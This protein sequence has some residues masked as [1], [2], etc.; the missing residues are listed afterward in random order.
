[1]A[2][3][4]R[5]VSSEA[6]RLPLVP[7]AFPTTGFELIDSSVKFEEEKLPFY[8]RDLFDPITLGQ[9]LR[10][11]YQVHIYPITANRELEI[12]DYLKTVDANDHPG[13]NSI[14]T[15][16]DTFLLEGVRG[17]HQVF[18]FPPL[19]ASLRHFQSI[20]RRLVF[21]R[22]VVIMAPVELSTSLNFLHGIANIT[23]TDIHAGNLLFGVQ[24]ESALE[25]FEETE[26]AKPSARKIID[27]VTIHQ[28][29]YIVAS[30]APV[31][32]CDLGE[33][34]IGDEH[35]GPIMP[36][37]YRAPE[38]ILGMR[39][40]H[41]VD[42]WSVGILAWSLLEPQGLTGTYDLEDPEQN[43]V[44]HLAVLTALLGPP[45]AE[46]MERSPECCK[47]WDKDG[48]WRGSVALSTEY[49]FEVLEGSLEG[50]DKKRF[51]DF[52][53]GLLRWL[54][55]ERLDSY[56]I[57]MHPWVSEPKAE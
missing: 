15:I 47:Y 7:R 26:M 34:R 38:V 16:R 33:A 19:G 12:N 50:E 2:T 9:V 4:V 43:D 53:R 29:R 41:A 35:E 49:T 55:E 20:Q 13:L 57:L 36:L 14:R 39:W 8:T 27:G 5:A 30:L 54:P 6:P 52:I 31:H 56:Q 11:R 24:D 37:S 45:P 51:L 44:I 17:L 42:L 10:D 48:K 28:T 25:I 32:L 46:F 21:N 22:A 18:I 40:D 23:H 3:S 1:M